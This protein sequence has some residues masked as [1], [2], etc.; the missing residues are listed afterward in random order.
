MKRNKKNSTDLS[1]KLAFYD[2]QG[3]RK[4]RVIFRADISQ[5]MDTDKNNPYGWLA[6]Y[7]DL[8]EKDMLVHFRVYKK[9]RVN[10]LRSWGV[11][12]RKHITKN[13][14]RDHK[15]Y[16]MAEAYEGGTNYKKIAHEWAKSNRQDVI[17]MLLKY[18]WNNPDGCISPDLKEAIAAAKSKGKVFD[19]FFT[20]SITSR[21]TK[22]LTHDLNNY[23]EF[24][25]PRLIR[26]A[27]NRYKELS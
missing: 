4:E 3:K 8:T 25:L 13:A 21:K 17:D 22:K 20:E 11:K 14:L 9:E 7:D 26:S 6:L 18:L 1:K 10:N 2:L 19:T 12:T 27:A 16:K 24:N 5:F 15:W 23:I